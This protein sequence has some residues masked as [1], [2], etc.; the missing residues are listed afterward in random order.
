MYMPISDPIQLTP[1]VNC[2]EWRPKAVGEMAGSEA[3]SARE[4]GIT[5]GLGTNAGTDL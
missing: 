5:P 4:R 1:F 2:T 3:R